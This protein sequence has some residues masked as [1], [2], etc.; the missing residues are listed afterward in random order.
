MIE[1]EQLLAKLRE[2]DKEFYA[3]GDE[4]YGD[5]GFD[6]IKVFSKENFSLNNK[7]SVLG[8]DIYKY[9]EYKKNKQNL[10]PFI[11]DYIY[12]KTLESIENSK[13]VIL[14][15]EI[16]LDKSKYFISTGDGG[17]I[18]FKTPI[19]ALIFNLHFFAVLHLFN[20]GHFFSKLSKYVDALVIRSALTYD[21]VYEYE[22]KYFGK[23]I[24]NNSRILSKDRLNR[25]I[26]D[27]S[28]FKY[29]NRKCNGI[30]TISI[31]C[32]ENIEKILQERIDGM[33]F[34][35]R[36]ENF[37]EYNNPFNNPVI[38]SIHVQKIDDLQSKNTKMKLYNVEIQYSATWY[39]DVETNQ[40]TS[41]I[42]TIGNLNSNNLN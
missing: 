36:R 6:I 24:I 17:F 8:L 37:N 23:A 34:F 10:I 2:I 11:F 38:R 32:V 27:E 25:F 12:D 22:G 26:F 18:L 42:L 20:T 14:F 19:H 15:K 9:S 13:E 41:F 30:E 5:D 35:Q 31:L 1:K 33:A 40:A 7:M 4:D 3:D 29:F 39:N 21:K 16:L 28:V